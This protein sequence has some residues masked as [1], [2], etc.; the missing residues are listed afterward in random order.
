[1]IYL[2]LAYFSIFVIEVQLETNVPMCLRNQF[3]E[4]GTKIVGWML[5][6]MT[7]TVLI[8]QPIS[9]KMLKKITPVRLFLSSS[10]IYVIGLF[11][12]TF[13]GWTFMFLSAAI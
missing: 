3:G 6:A 2:F 7:V 12:F 4:T 11:V 5:S 8:I 13:S 10:V 1:S 9:L